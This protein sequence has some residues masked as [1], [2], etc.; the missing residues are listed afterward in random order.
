MSSKPT[1]LVTGAAGF[2][3]AALSTRLAQAGYTV[4]GVDNLS[5]YYDVTLKHMRLKNLSEFKNFTFL[6]HD[7]A[8]AKAMETLFTKY[9]PK[10]VM[11]LAA[12]A[13]VRYSL[14]HPETYIHSNLNG[15]AVILDCCKKNEIEH[16]IYASTSSVY[17]SNTQMPFSPSHSADH[18]LSLYAA[19]KRA[20]E[21]LA[22]SYSAMFDMP[23]T[24]I[25]F[26]T[27]YGPWGRPDMALFKFTKS[28]LSGEPIDVYNYGKH[29]RDF[30][31]VDDI[32][33]G[34]QKVLEKTPPKKDPNYNHHQPTPQKSSAPY[35]IYNLG[36]Q[37]PIPLMKYIELA[38]KNLGKT[39]EKN[40]LPLQAA[41]IPDTHAD[42]TEFFKDFDFKPST[43][44]ETGVKNFVDWYIK[45]YQ[46]RNQQ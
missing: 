21:L 6:E 33:L 11:H 13:G 19:T 8:D 5:P 45:F 44:V 2:I 4:V 26:F 30:T 46:S 17:G 25:R 9:Q 15:F 34:L 31:Y 35:R 28:I 24:G 38:E 20:N 41:D 1:V 43:P 39:A 12:Q 37:N 14:T 3:G 16:L 40:M 10:Q 36:S 32:T 22:H 29:T 42:M 18:P 7:I 23:T 27:V